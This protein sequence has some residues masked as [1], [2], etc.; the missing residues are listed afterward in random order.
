MLLELS[1][2]VLG[3]IDHQQLA[4]GGEDP[5]RLGDRR[6]RLLRVVQHLVQD[7]AVRA[8]IA[9]RKRVH[10]ALAKAGAAY[11]CFIQFHPRQSKHFR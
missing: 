9:K 6:S 7:D 11:P 10:V 4:V 8:V 3:K 2:V 1:P 5:R